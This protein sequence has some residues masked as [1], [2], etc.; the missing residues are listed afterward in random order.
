MKAFAGLFPLGKALAHFGNVMLNYLLL[1]YEFRMP[2]KGSCGEG[3]ALHTGLL[4]S[5]GNVL[6]GGVG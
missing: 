2:S 6:E 3:L 5:S 1:Q 4:G